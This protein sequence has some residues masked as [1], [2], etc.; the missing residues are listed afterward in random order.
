M[1]CKIVGLKMD[2][3]AKKKKKGPTFPKTSSIQS[4]RR[5]VL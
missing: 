4:K 5:P 1:N 3:E 2:T